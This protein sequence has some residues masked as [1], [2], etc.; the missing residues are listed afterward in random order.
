MAN[1][2]RIETLHALTEALT[3]QGNDLQQALA[4]QAAWQQ[5]INTLVHRILEQELEAQH[6]PPADVSN[7]TRRQKERAR[8]R[9]VLLLRD[10]H[11]T[12]DDHARLARIVN[13]HPD[14]RALG[15]GNITNENVRWDCK[16]RRHK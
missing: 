2:E 14:Y 16:P 15:L 6:A 8:K 13:A 12:D 4:Q 5:T 7:M 10:L 9:L 1:T 11:D 3:H